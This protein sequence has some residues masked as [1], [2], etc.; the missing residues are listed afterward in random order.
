MMGNLS[1]FPPEELISKYRSLHQSA[2][3]SI[4]EKEVVFAHAKLLLAEGKVIEALAYL[5]ALFK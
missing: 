4:K 2:E 1:S 5:L 3:N